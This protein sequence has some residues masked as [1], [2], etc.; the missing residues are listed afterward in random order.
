MAKYR[1]L[2]NKCIFDNKITLSLVESVILNEKI[3]LDTMKKEI[4]SKIRT[5][6]DRK[7]IIG[8]FYQ[9][10]D[11]VFDKAIQHYIVD[12]NLI[13]VKSLDKMIKSVITST[14]D[15]FE[16]SKEF[17]EKL[18]ENM[19]DEK[20][21]LSGTKVNLL[22]I[23]NTKYKAI[24]EALI[25]RTLELK[26]SGGDEGPGEIALEIISSNIT[27]ANVGDLIIGTTEVEVK[28]T[29]ARLIAASFPYNN[30]PNLLKKLHEELAT[31]GFINPTKYFGFKL[32][33][34]TEINK[35]LKTVDKSTANK[36]DKHIGSFFKSMYGK[37][38][39]E[40][41]ASVYKNQ[42]IDV[43]NW[44]LHFHSMIFNLYKTTDGFD[45]IL[46]INKKSL[47][48]VYIKTIKDLQSNFKLFTTNW[49]PDFDTRTPSGIPQMW[50][51][52]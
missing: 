46:F 47:N 48:V 24:L 26:R 9:I 1:K 11:E 10:Y 52:S 17:I 14:S 30:A 35:H 44:K 41:W 29:Q 25:K 33:V 12:N 20:K 50:L 4:I 18:G 22:D 40:F 31:T 8:L 51:K 27:K 19:I 43:D 42:E 6:K 38:G 5:T 45:G 13:K 34:I 3:E 23:V 36:I 39:E 21:L 49:G 37:F 15:D 7:M 2:L 32:G 16:T 28:S